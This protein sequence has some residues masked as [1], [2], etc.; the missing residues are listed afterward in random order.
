M[1]LSKQIF[2]EAIK[3]A[4][5]L[6]FERK[7]FIFR[8]IFNSKWLDQVKQTL[9]KGHSSNLK[10]ENELCDARVWHSCFFF[11][12][13]KAKLYVETDWDIVLFIFSFSFCPMLYL[14]ITF[15]MDPGHYICLRFLSSHLCIY[16]FEPLSPHYLLALFL[17][18]IE[19]RFAVFVVVQLHTYTLP[20]R[21]VIQLTHFPWLQHIFVLFPPFASIF[22]RCSY[23]AVLSW[24]RCV[25][26]GWGTL[27]ERHLMFTS[28]LRNDKRSACLLC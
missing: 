20:L 28:R 11:L 10:Q 27:G 22:S 13:K 9:S 18:C 5:F 19:R 21:S 6:L 14:F 16:S 12:E 4:A 3:C 2:I 24:N 15:T 1:K 17:Y 25:V 8:R 7:T 23:S 26:G